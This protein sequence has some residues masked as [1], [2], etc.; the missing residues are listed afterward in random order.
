[1]ITPS[2]SYVLL[3]L[4]FCISLVVLATILLLREHQNAIIQKG[5][6]DRLLVSQGHN[7]LPDIEPI[8]DL[9]GESKKSEIT[10]KIE[11]AVAKIKRMKT[12]G[13]PV[14]FSIP[15]MPQPRAGMGEVKRNG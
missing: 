5:L 8:A 14:R 3:L 7:P 6:I 11:D 12:Q 13:S 10:E 1:M 15:G 2:M 4:P 9:T